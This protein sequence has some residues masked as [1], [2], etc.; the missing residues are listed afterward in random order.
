MR[1]FKHFSDNHRGKSMQTL[2]DEMG[3]LGMSSWYILMEMCTEKLEKKWDKK[4]EDSDCLFE[5]HQRVVRRNLRI[6]PTNLGRLLDICQSFGLLSFRIVG[7]IIEIKMP[8]LL[9]LLESDQKKSRRCSVRIAPESRLESELKLE[10][11][12]D[13]DAELKLL[14]DVTTTEKPLLKENTLRS[15]SAQRFDDSYKPEVLE[16]RKIIEELGITSSPSLKRM[17]PDIARS[18]E[19]NVE[20]FRTWCRDILNSDYFSRISDNGKRTRYFIAA[21]K[22]EVKK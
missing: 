13:V 5:F 6:S 11:N 20:D 1:W 17:V 10:L 9:D 14:K 2:F 4:L 7:D 8:I 21:L 18:Y 19:F 22:D 15:N 12:V 16:F 3:H